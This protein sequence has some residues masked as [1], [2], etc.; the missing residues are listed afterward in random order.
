MRST[1][2]TDEAVVAFRKLSLKLRDVEREEA[3]LAQR[4][5]GLTGEELRDYVSKTQDIENALAATEGASRQAYRA[6]ANAAGRS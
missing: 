3:E 4:V 2:A 5:A 6:A 1:R